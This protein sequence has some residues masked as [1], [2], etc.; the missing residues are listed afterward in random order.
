[1]RRYFLEIKLEEI[2]MAIMQ[3]ISWLNTVEKKH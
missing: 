3:K 1:M 2:Q